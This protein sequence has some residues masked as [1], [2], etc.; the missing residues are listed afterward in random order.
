MRQKARKIM[1]YNFKGG[2][3]KTFL[4]SNTAS[5]LASKGFKTLL[6]DLDPQSNSS[7]ALFEDQ[8]LYRDRCLDQLFHPYA[9][10]VTKISDVIYPV[11]SVPNLYVAPSTYDLE[12]SEAALN[13]KSFTTRQDPEIV[14]ASLLVEIEDQFD[15]I[16]MDTNSSK[17]R[18]LNL[19]GFIA[20][21]YLFIPTDNDPYALEGI[22]AII[23]VYNTCKDKNPKLKIGGIIYSK[24]RDTSADM[25]AIGELSSI[26]L[27]QNTMML[28]N[29]FIPLRVAVV[30]SRYKHLPFDVQFPNHEITQGL[31]DL[32]DEIDERINMLEV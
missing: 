21:D 12:D 4:A 17:K 1:Y 8:R 5:V 7:K 13:L 27:N 32:V 25:K 14:L 29:T 30:N 15:Y 18:L 31:R 26:M 20:T 3:A 22:S 11:E 28:M 19:N 24:A 10:N 16:I 9:K 2:V 23:E 6:I